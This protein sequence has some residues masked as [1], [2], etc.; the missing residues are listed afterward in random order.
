MVYEL[1]NVRLASKLDLTLS[2]SIVFVTPTKAF[3]CVDSFISSL[4]DIQ[5]TVM[6]LLLSFKR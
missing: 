3:L 2:Q 1:I 6:T 4:R 5:V